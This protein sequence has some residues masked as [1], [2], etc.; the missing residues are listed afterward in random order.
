MLHTTQLVPLLSYPGSI[1]FQYLQ[2]AGIITVNNLKVG[3]CINLVDWTFW[4]H[5]AQ[6]LPGPSAAFQ[7]ANDIDSYPNVKMFRLFG[8]VRFWVRTTVH[9]L[10]VQSI[11]TA[12]CSVAG[13][14]AEGTTSQNRALHA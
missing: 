13:V 9:L 3:S 5:L 12:C 1:Q 7:V 10:T 11:H 4:G 2:F 14:Q 6:V 8:R